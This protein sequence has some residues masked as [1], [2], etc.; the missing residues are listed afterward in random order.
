MECRWLIVPGNLEDLFG[1]DQETSVAIQ[2]EIPGN[3]RTGTIGA[4]DKTCLYTS[5]SFPTR[6]VKPAT[7]PTDVARAQRYPHSGLDG[8]A[9]CRLV[10]RWHIGHPVLVARA[11]QS[12]RS[13]E[14]RRVEHD[15]SNRRPQTLRW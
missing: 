13:T 9:S 1:A 6:Y 4:D 7:S 11:H 15:V 8:G 5:E 2:T 12:Y 3:P 14:A 10:Q